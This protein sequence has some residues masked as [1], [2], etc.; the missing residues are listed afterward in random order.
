MGKNS[1]YS[2]ALNDV[3]RTDMKPVDFQVDNQE[4]TVELTGYWRDIIGGNKS[5]AGNVPIAQLNVKFMGDGQKYGCK[6]SIWRID[7]K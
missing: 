4:G 1:R 2:G 3:S 6:M 7:G 5:D